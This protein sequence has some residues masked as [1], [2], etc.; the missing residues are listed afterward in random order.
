MNLKNKNIEKEINREDL[1]Y[2][3]GIQKK[4]KIYGFL[5]FKII[6]SFGR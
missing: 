2:K 6:K 4:S 1:I 5:Y 3:T